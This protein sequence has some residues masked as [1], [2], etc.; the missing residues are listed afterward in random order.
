MEAKIKLPEVPEQEFCMVFRIL[1]NS[2][3]HVLDFNNASSSIYG[4]KVLRPRE[5][6]SNQKFY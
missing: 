5:E 3:V 4:V 6:D 1:L 2:F